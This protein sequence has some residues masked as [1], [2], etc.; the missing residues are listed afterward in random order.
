MK[1]RFQ[2]IREARVLGFEVDPYTNIDITEL[3]FS[4]EDLQHL[5]YHF[6]VFLAVSLFGLTVDEKDR[7]TRLDTYLDT[8]DARISYEE[9]ARKTLYE[10]S[11]ALETNR[12]NNYSP[13]ETRLGSLMQEQVP[14]ETPDH[15]AEDA[16]MHDVIVLNNS[17]DDNQDPMGFS[18][19][20]NMEISMVHVL[21]AKF[22][23]TTH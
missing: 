11:Q 7:V 20:E 15:Q 2:Y 16:L 14:V 18:I 21:P 19:L 5:R 9:R 3:P 23:P 10:Q 17:E 6:K 1:T 12:L 13:K 8:R 22:Q 4:L